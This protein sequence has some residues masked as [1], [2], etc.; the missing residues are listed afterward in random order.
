MANFVHGNDGL[1]L[2]Y[3]AVKRFDAVG[4]KDVIAGYH[5]EDAGDI[6]RSPDINF[7]DARMWHRAAQDS[8]MTHTRYLHVGQVLSLAADFAL[9]IQPPK[10]LADICWFHSLAPYSRCYL[11]FQFFSC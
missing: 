9:V 8:T 6:Q 7:L 10:G 1:I 5:R 2:E 11:F 3:R 4:S